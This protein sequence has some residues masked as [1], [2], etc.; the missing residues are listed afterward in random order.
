[1]TGLIAQIWRHPIKSHGHE[2]LE[3]VDVSEGRTL[4]W[5]RTWAVAHEAAK[6]DGIAWVP[7][8]NFSR[9]SKAPGLMALSA[10]LD[11]AQARITL[12]HPDQGQ[13]SF[14]PDDPADLQG[15]LDWTR[16]LVPDDRAQS[17]KILRVP[18]RGMTDTD[19][20]SISLAGLGT[21]NALSDR[22]GQPLDPRRFRINFWID[23]LKPW[24]EFN[25][26]GRDIKID[27]L[28]FHVEEPI[29]RCLATTANP[30][31]GVRDADILGALDSGWGHR[32]LGVYLRALD[33]GKISLGDAVIP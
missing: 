16:P 2:A 9:G 10:K 23:G 27:G 15:F 31:T 17:A 12:Q 13:F 25:W 22:V 33:S 6:A 4:P 24:E 18:D 3:T 8:Q 32:D 28:L 21:L 19:F 30:E 11:E 5:D 29:T 1:M 20:P 26:I 14:R 7:C